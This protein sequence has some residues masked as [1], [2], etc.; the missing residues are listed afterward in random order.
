[1]GNSTLRRVTLGEAWGG[2]TLNPYLQSSCKVFFDRG[3]SSWKCSIG[4]VIL[5]D[6]R[7]GT[8]TGG[9]F[10]GM[11]VIV[12]SGGYLGGG[13]KLVLDRWEAIHAVA[14]RQ[15]T[16]RL[17]APMGRAASRMTECWWCCE[18]ASS[19]RIPERVDA[20]SIGCSRV[21]RE[22]WGMYR[23]TYIPMSF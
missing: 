5:L 23:R 7:T 13:S 17:A 9:W 10:A 20:F 19:I 4:S 16:K 2:L 18:A 15:L 6:Q 21:P 3:T 14:N 8:R 22:V 1:M 11:K 12:Q